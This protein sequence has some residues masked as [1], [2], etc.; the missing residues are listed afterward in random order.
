[1]ARTFDV[2]LSVR[3]LDEGA[4]IAAAARDMVLSLIHI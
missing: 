2:T 4:V 1:M 3:V